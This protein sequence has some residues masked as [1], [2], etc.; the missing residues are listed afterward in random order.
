MVIS[1]QAH[2]EGLYVEGSET[3]PKGSRAPRWSSKRLAPISMGDDIVHPI[4]KLLDKCNQLVVGS[5]P[6]PGALEKTSENSFFLCVYAG[7][8]NFL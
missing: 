4:R 5:N 1:S 3:I 2:I 8:I 7:E 6:T